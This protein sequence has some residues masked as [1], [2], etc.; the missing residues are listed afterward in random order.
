MP[1]VQLHALAAQR[2]QGLAKF[3]HLGRAPVRWQGDLHH[4][5]IRFGV[6]VH[7]RHPGAV[8]KGALRV[9]RRL[10][11]RGLQQLQHILRQ[12]RVA[13]YR[14][15]EALAADK[16][17]ALGRL[18]GVDIHGCEQPLDPARGAVHNRLLRALRDALGVALKKAIYNFMHGIG[19]EQDVRRW[20]DVPVPKPRVARWSLDV[21]PP[22]A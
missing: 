3:A 4:R 18:V 20:F 16:K 19:L 11:T 9:W 2:T 7:Q 8:V 1:H 6:E 10:D 13:V 21:D 22:E 14:L 15:L 12:R 17:S 5:N